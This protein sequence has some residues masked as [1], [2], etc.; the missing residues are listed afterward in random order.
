[1]NKNKFGEFLFGVFIHLHFEDNDDAEEEF[2]V[3][4]RSQNPFEPSEVIENGSSHQTIKKRSNLK[5]QANVEEEIF[6][7]TNKSKKKSLQEN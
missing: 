1:M 5:P 4:K 2:G 6:S 3:Q 7:K